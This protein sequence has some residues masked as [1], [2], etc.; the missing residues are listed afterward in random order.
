M[1]VSVVADFFATLAS[2]P[3]PDVSHVLA[4]ESIPRLASAFAEVDRDETSPMASSAV[5][6]LDSLL[7]GQRVG[8]GDAAFATLAPR[9]FHLL[10]KSEDRDVLQVISPCRRRRARRCKKG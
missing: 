4:A 1:L 10:E 3:S 7:G 5:T 6:I 2:S 8:L 9:L